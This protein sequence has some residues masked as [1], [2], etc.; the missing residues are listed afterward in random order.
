MLFRLYIGS[1]NT[2]KRLESAK[3]IGLISKLFKGFTAMQGIGY[4]EGKPEKS[5]IVE[6]ETDEP[7][8]VKLLAQGLCKELNQQAVAVAEIGKMSFIS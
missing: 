4:W 5:L 7:N 2:T 8:A 3:A 1:N 6:I